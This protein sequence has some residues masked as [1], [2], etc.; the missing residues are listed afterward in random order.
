M[1]AEN[2]ALEINLEI[3]EFDSTELAIKVTLEKYSSIGITEQYTKSSTWS[4]KL[5]ECIGMLGEARGYKVCASVC[6]KRFEPEW[7]FD[8]IWY[9]EEVGNGDYRFT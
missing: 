4:E 1:P 5:K 3:A 2:S 8:L 6:N 7:L 9:K